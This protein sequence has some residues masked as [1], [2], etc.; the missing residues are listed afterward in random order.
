MKVVCVIPAWNEEKNIVK[1]IKDVRS[2]VDEI[3]VVDDA[4]TDNTYKLCKDQNVTVLRH[5]I[6]RDQGAALK[7]GNDYALLHGADI[8]VHFDA[9]GQFLAEDINEAVAIIKKDN[10]DVVFGSRFLG[11]DSNMPWVKKN[12]LFPI[13]RRV[14]YF[15]LGIKLSDPQSGFRVMSRYAIEAV[16]VTQRGKAHC[17]EILHNVFKANLRVKEVPITVIY[18]RFGQNFSGGIRI[19]KDLLI[20]KLIND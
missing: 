8:V 19:V 16:P 1:V 2:K 18:N 11:K 14:N 7:T 20:A 9:D 4:S 6:N 10:A 13:A 5:V 12:I 3:V 15:L 17:S